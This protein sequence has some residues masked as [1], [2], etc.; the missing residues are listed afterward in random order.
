[1]YFWRWKKFYIE[2]SLG[3]SL[4]CLESRCRSPFKDLF[5]TAEAAEHKMADEKGQC[6]TLCLSVSLLSVERLY[7][8]TFSSAILPSGSSVL[9]KLYVL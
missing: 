3:N 9:A 5:V 4:Q 1:M 8:G 2:K 7:P 6:R